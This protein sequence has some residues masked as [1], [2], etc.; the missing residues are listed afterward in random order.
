[1]ILLNHGAF[2]GLLSAKFIFSKTWQSRSGS[3]NMKQGATYFQDALLGG[4][5]ELDN[6]GFI[7]PPFWACVDALGEARHL[8][9]EC[10]E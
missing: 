5:V 3:P 6:D 10:N 9:H 4:T 1:M 8:F 7:L 2:E